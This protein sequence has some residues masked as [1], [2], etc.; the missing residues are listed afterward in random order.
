[1][2]RTSSL[3]ALA[4]VPVLLAARPIE[5]CELRGAD[6]AG[7]PARS[8]LTCHD[9]SVAS[10]HLARADERGS[11][12]HPV[13]VEYALAQARGRGALR[14]A[15]AAELPLVGGKVT[16][17]T[18]HDGHSRE[19]AKVAVPMRGSALCFGCHDV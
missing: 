2:R 4:L 18:C 5:L 13:E 12:R 7:T 8:C 11:G 15:P 17:T 6:R 9:G 19:P 1:V 3:F 14:V 10:G 16:C